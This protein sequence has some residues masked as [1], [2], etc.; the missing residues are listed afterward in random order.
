MIREYQPKIESK[1]WS[2]KKIFMRLFLTNRRFDVSYYLIQ[3]S[4]LKF[5]NETSCTFTYKINLI[6]IILISDKK[7]ELQSSRLLFT[8]QNE[9]SHIEQ[10]G[11]TQNYIFVL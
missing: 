2:L 9:K 11:H 4:E 6:V 3:K 10:Q 7:N 8:R 5:G 1:K